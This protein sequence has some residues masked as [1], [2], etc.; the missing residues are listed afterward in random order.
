[1]FKVITTKKTY[2]DD[3]LICII[4]DVIKDCFSASFIQQWEHFMNE[5]ESIYIHNSSIRNEG[6]GNECEFSLPQHHIYLQFIQFIEDKISFKCKE[7]KLSV[8]DFFE[9]CSYVLNS[10]HCVSAAIDVFSAIIPLVTQFEAF[11]DVMLSR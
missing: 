7:Y 10:L 5:H 9:A 1:M 4:E 6:K 2:D 8:G 3:E 11:D